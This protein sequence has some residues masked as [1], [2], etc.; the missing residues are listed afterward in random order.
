ME[1]VELEAKLRK[2]V[3]TAS[4]RC[5]RRQG[6]V[7]AVV[8]GRDIKPT[9][10]EVDLKK[11]IMIT[12]GE[13]GYNIIIDL[14]ISEDSKSKKEQ[15]LTQDVQRDPLTGQV[16]HID[17]H[18]IIMTEEIKTKVPVELR[19]ESI[20][21]KEDEGILIHSLREIEIKCLPAE[22]PEKFELD[23]SELKI[24]D[25]LH[26]SDIKAGKGIE[27]LTP[28][29]E[30]VVNIAPPTKEEEIAPPPELVP[31]AEVPAE[32]GAPPPEVP[33]EEKAKEK[34]KPEAKAPAPKEE[35]KAPAKE[36]KPGKEEKK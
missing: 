23:V 5:L 19:G 29:T 14:K 10:V 3:G 6:R 15:V 12:S 17:F 31:A 30:M 4:S 25:T 16:I 1:K 7:P 28:G 13:A 22:I 21:V 2:K 36:G 18:K 33:P 32:K 24:G 8:Y 20:G 9:N 11:F 26:V 34:A 35:A 27:I